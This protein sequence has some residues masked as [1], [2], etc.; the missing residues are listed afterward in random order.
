MSSSSFCKFLAR[1][2]YSPLT[3]CSENK[4]NSLK[5][6]LSINSLPTCMLYWQQLIIK[7]LKKRKY[8]IRYFF[9]IFKIH[10]SFMQVFFFNYLK[11][12]EDI[13]ILSGNINSFCQKKNARD[14]NNYHFLL[15]V[16]GSILSPQRTDSPSAWP[17][18]MQPNSCRQLGAS[19]Q[20]VS[21]LSTTR[22]W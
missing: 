8:K 1:W 12:M 20:A 5:N 7:F 2:N 21:A 15:D 22:I 16:F 19:Y 13:I 3:S 17:I 6:L 11:I 10:I 18:N 4:K 9:K 14:L